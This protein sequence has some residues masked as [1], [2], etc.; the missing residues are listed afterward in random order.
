MDD[1]GALANERETRLELR[2]QQ[3][4]QRRGR[5]DCSTNVI[6]ANLTKAHPLQ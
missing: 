5:Q 4:L 3:R 2:L 1:I 6:T